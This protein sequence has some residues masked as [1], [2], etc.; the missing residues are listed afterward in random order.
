MLAS[1]SWL[2]PVVNLFVPW[3]QLQAVSRH[4]KASAPVGVWWLFSLAGVVANRVVVA[5]VEGPTDDLGSTLARV[6]VVSSI[7][8]LCFVVAGVAGLRSVAAIQS[9]SRSRA[10]RHR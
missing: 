2:V 6:A 9:C 5:L 1:L 10:E 4:V 8:A 7:S 3:R